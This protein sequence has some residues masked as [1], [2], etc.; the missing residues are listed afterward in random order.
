MIEPYTIQWQ[1]IQ[2]AVRNARIPPALFFVGPL[3]CNIHAFTI[4]ALQLL[5]CKK[6][7]SE[8][9][10]CLTCPDCQM[11]ARIEHPD[12]YWVKPEKSG[13]AIKID[14]IRE[15]HTIAFLTPQRAS[16]R[17]III[18]YADKMNV[19]AAN[20]LLKILEEPSAHTH[21]ILIGEQVSTV[22]PTVLSRCQLTPF[23]AHDNLA[24]LLELGSYYPEDSER[25]ALTRQAESMI[26]GLIAIIKKEQH[27]CIL[28]AQ[29]NQFELPNLLWFLYLVYSQVSYLTSTDINPESLAY[30]SLMALKVLTTPILIFEQID[31]INKILKKLSHNMNINQLL[32]LEDLLFS[33]AR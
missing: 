4:E 17:F 33:L 14:Q 12:V 1:K 27:P 19:A 28:A 32:V 25:T 7:S 29:W 11:V 16:Y 13:S 10:P 15:L 9:V 30:K 8:L 2:N 26:A 18:E 5:L 23:S 3:H 20:A 24:N 22:L 31:K 6:N 21:F